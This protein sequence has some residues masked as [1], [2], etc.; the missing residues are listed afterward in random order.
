MQLYIQ[1]IIF[2][3]LTNI[4]SYPLLRVQKS[5]LKIRNNFINN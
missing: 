4:F 3:Q 2:Y 5:K 1:D